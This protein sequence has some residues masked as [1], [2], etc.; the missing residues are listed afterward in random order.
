MKFAI[1][2]AMGLLLADQ[3]AAFAPYTPISKTYNTKGSS[4]RVLS[5]A[6]DMPPAVQSDVPVIQKMAYGLTD[7][8]YSDFLKL[9]DGDKMEK[10]TFSAD[11]TQL[12]G[13]DVDGTRM[14]IESL[15]NDPE[16]LSQLTSHKVRKQIFLSF[17]CPVALSTHMICSKLVPK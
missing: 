16:L 4:G 7:V 5:M 15:P 12:L 8:R 13:V 6:M 14:K 2:A 3:A 1:T 17:R 11:G 9:V 10:V